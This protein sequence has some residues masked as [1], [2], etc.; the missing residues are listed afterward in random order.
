MDY[1]LLAA[2][3]RKP[4]GDFGKTVAGNMNH[5]NSAINLHTIQLLQVSAYDTV[6]EIG[7]SN[8]F[9]CKDVLARHASV[10]YTGC[11]FSELMVEEA[12]VLNQEMIKE[13]RARFVL[14]DADVLP[15]EDNSFSKL[16]TVNTIYFWE[17]PLQPLSEIYRVLEPGGA[18]IISLRTKES[19]LQ[20]RFVEY[21]FHLFEEDDLLPL[22]GETGFSSIKIIH[23]PDPPFHIAE[24]EIQLHSLYAVCRK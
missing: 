19:M 18:A 6:L 22:L 21:G 20:M 8:G 3:L 10:T 1:A 24:Q 4:E 2:Q 13:G 17:H 15:F 5:S 9:F 14:A 11:D 12:T 7:M 16:F 23:E